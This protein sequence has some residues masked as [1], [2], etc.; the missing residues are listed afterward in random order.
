MVAYL[1]PF[2]AMAQSSLQLQGN[3]VDAVSKE[4][5]PF[6]SVVLISKATESPVKGVM[7]DEQGRFNLST[8][9]VNVRLEIR[10]MGFETYSMPSLP[11]TE[12]MIELGEIALILATQNLDE[13]QVLA[14]RSTMEFKL[15]RRVFNVGK[16][17]VS[18]GA[19]ALEVLNNV[20]SVNVDIEGNIS[21]R[22]SQGVQILID[23]KP[24]VSDDPRNALGSITADMIESIEV[25][26]NPSAKYQA[27]GTSGIINIILKKEEKTGLNGSVS[28]NTG[29]PA[30]HSVGGSINYRTKKM[31]FFTQFGAGYRSMPTF[32]EST[33]QSRLDL[34]LIDSEG[35]SF[36]N[37]VFYNITLG[38]DYFLNDNNTLT[39][40]GNYA[41]EIEDNPSEIN[42]LISDSTGQ[43]ISDFLRLEETTATNPK[44]QY[45][46]QY[47]KQFKSHKD[48]VL[49]ASAQGRFFGKD[50]ESEFDNI[51]ALGDVG[52]IDQRTFADFYQ[53]DFIYKLDYTNP[54]SKKVKIELGGMY[55]INDVGNDYEV[56]DLIDEQWFTNVNLTNDFNYN[57]SVIGV[58]GTG[59]YE[60]AKWGL[61]LGLRMEGTDLT[62]ILENTNQRNDQNYSNLFPTVHTS[63]KVSDHFSVQAGY[64]KRIFRPR[65]WDLNPFFNIQNNFNIRTGNPELLPEFADS[66]E[67]TT[68]LLQDKWSLNTSI[69]HLYTTD[70][71]ESVS[72]YNDG[73]NLT[74]RENVGTNRKTGLEISGKYNPLKWL[75]I[76]GDF[77]YGFFNR[78]GEFEG[79]I[80]DFKGDQYSGKFTAKLKLKKNID[81]EFSPNYQS[82][83]STLQ[84]SSSG[85]VSL[86]AGIR[87]KVLKEK[88]VVSIGLRDVFASRIQESFVDQTD[89]YLR[90]FSQRGRFLTLG[91]SYSFGKGEVMSYT[92]GGRRG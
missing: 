67:F 17:I 23:G 83:F 9:S 40:S 39:L 75:S 60:A 43:L 69:Y 73:V 89:F 13:A 3:V 86:D 31:N 33:N 84:G 5:L 92:G 70:V 55:E 82:A 36:R 21:L 59:A 32:S 80:F 7:T 51:Y 71:T 79:R 49:L 68:I 11:K 25:I 64:S 63:Y 10:F 4:P 48:H 50:Q 27:G 74:T 28:L 18:T 35:E 1:L 42:I 57:Q 6:V 90:S 29:M 26:T 66:Y 76:N 34:G 58:Y 78:Q 81:V 19:G 46:L 2:S 61:K 62:T 30:N 12:G 44:W 56:Q 20:P 38:A 85:F 88:A 24:A 41:Y 72:F 16:D 45:D 65:L 91:F 52:A 37:E 15:D 14:E 22:G 87:K 47:K 54:I 53:A 8:D 77:N